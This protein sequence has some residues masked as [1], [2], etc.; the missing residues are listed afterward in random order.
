MFITSFFI[1]KKKYSLFLL[2]PFLIFV[3]RQVEGLGI[4][5]MK[6]IKRYYFI[7][8]LLMLIL[9]FVD[10]VLLRIGYD[11]L[12]ITFEVITLLF[13]LLYGIIKL[14]IKKYILFMFGLLTICILTGIVEK[15]FSFPSSYM[16]YNINLWYHYGLNYFITIS[17]DFVY[18]IILSVIFCVIKN[19]KRGH[20]NG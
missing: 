7:G 8:I 20:I 9:R 15:I 1:T 16:I 12:I 2:R 3:G 6:N 19:I 18:I 5:M 11:S 13:I 10:I 17:Y 14:D 4:Y